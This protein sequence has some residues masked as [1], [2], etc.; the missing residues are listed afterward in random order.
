MNLFGIEI[1]MWVMVAV[2]VLV[3]LTGILGYLAIRISPTARLEIFGTQIDMYHLPYWRMRRIPKASG[4]LAFS[5]ETAWMGHGTAKYIKDK[6][7]YRLDDRIRELAPIAPGSVLTIPVKR[8]PAKYLIVA[9]IYDDSKR[10]DSLSFCKGFDAAVEAL[11]NSIPNSMFP[12]NSLMM[13]DPTDDWNYFEKR[14]SPNVSARLVLDAIAKC[15]GR[16]GAVRIIV[17]KSENA[18]AY[19][20]EM[21]RISEIRHEYSRD[22][23]HA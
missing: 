11:S 2:P 8:L 20:E 12:G 23:R 6:A 14:I 5:D 3:V 21:E 4:F 16:V 1:P 9:N 10:L 17:P 15:N 13:G 7:D 19:K 18:K 22:L